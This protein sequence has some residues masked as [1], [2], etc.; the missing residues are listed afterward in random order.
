M[1]IAAES[2]LRL[3]GAGNVLRQAASPQPRAL[4]FQMQLRQLFSITNTLEGE[5]HNV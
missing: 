4:H 2:Y 3:K 1:L 5:N